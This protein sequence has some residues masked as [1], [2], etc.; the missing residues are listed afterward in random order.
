M[1]IKSLPK[2]RDVLKNNNI[3]PKKK[4]GQNFLC[5]FNI[6]D[7]I[8]RLAGPLKKF[9]IIEVGPGPGGLTRSIMKQEPYQMIIV[10]KDERFMRPLD[11]INKFY[12]NNIKIINADALNLNINSLTNFP[13]KIIAN[14]PYN[15]ATKL[16]IN[17]LPLSKN[18]AGLYLMFQKEVAQRIVAKPKTKSYGRLSIITQWSCDVNI[19]MNIPAKA[20]VPVPKI[21]SCF[22]QFLP[23]KISNDEFKTDTLSKVTQ[24][25]FSQRRKM[26]KT[27]LSSLGNSKL[28]CDKANV[29]Y[30]LRADALS[31][32]E[33]CSISKIVEKLL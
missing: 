20:F 31:V 22:V 13:T 8:V 23:K 27:S 1:I 26:I 2:I 28:I 18:I 32:A 30:N 4:Y 21:D 6:L 5:D 9:C 7:K 24:L 17:L 14:L 15:I 16:I 19:I 33:Y 12:S 29:N 10:E 11:D 3:H 25:T